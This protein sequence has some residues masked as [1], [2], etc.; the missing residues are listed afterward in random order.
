MKKSHKEQ[1]IGKPEE[2]KGQG[3]AAGKQ[4]KAEEKSNKL[5]SG[6]SQFR[7]SSVHGLVCAAIMVVSWLV[8]RLQVGLLLHCY[9]GHGRSLKRALLPPSSLYLRLEHVVNMPSIQDLHAKVSNPFTSSST[10]LIIQLALYR[11]RRL[12]LA[13]NSIS[14]TSSPFLVCSLFG[15]TRHKTISKSQIW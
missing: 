7:S 9:G 13:A 4:P 8:E 1:W 12:F 6:A 15:N 10:R 14:A 11:A 3:G 2:R 5:A